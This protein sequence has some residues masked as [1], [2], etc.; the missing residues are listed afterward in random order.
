MPAGLWTL[1]VVLIP[2]C[3]GFVV[4]FLVRKSAGHPC[5]NCGAPLGQDAL[6]C[7]RC[8]HQLMRPVA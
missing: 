5:P 7:S 3:L 2:N 8:G 6:F 4:Y 1:L